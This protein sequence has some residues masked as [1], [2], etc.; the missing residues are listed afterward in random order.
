MDKYLKSILIALLV[1]I[2]VTGL[3]IGVAYLLQY[4]LLKAAVDIISDIVPVSPPTTAEKPS[5][6]ISDIYK[7]LAS[8]FEDYKFKTASSRVTVL[9]YIFESIKDIKE[10]TDME[11]YKLRFSYLNLIGD[12]STLS[13]YSIYMFAKYWEAI[14]VIYH[15]RIFWDHASFPDIDKYYIS[16][17]KF[18]T[19]KP[20]MVELA[21]KYISILGET[22]D[23]NNL[24]DDKL[25]ELYLVSSTS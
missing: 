15:K 19:W 16:F 4:L 3:G 14:N 8:D 25:Y 7:L 11:I 18:D 2:V 9:N 21:T 13:D 17:K 5:T 20:T 6:K 22:T 1:V 24:P 23:A 10:N 12:G